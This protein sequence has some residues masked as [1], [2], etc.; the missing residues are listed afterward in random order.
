MPKLSM[1]IRQMIFIIHLFRADMQIGRKNLQDALE[2]ASYRPLGGQAAR[3]YR[4]QAELYESNPAATQEQKQT[5]SRLKRDAEKIKNEVSRMNAAS[6]TLP[7]I[8]EDE[9]YDNLV[10][11][12]FR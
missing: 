4:K 2:I 7:L 12:Y 3:I 9:Q 6:I 8:G 11:A 1:F 10:C 5:V